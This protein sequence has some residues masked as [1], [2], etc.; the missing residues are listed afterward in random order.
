MKS[1]RDR[2][3]NARTATNAK[4]RSRKS[5]LFWWL[6]VAGIFLMGKIGERTAKY[7]PETLS[8]RETTLIE[9]MVYNRVAG[10]DDDGMF[11]VED[12]HCV[13][14]SGTS[15]VCQPLRRIPGLSLGWPQVTSNA[16]RT[17]ASRDGVSGNIPVSR[18]GWRFTFT[19]NVHLFSC[20]RSGGGARIPYRRN[21]GGR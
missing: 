9:K 15:H 21:C 18:G 6:L 17:Q 11:G 19:R 1:I 20:A 12:K 14:A 10:Q 2:Q 5:V 4:P 8:T 13:I 16:F 3:L 7:A